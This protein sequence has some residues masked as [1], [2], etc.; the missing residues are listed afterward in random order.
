MKKHLL[1]F[2]MILL[3]ALMIPNVSANVGGDTATIH[4]TSSPS[5]ANVYDSGEYKGTTPCDIYV[6]TTGTPVNHNI[7]VSKSGY[8]DYHETIYPPSS[9]DYISV[10]AILTPIS[11]Q[12]YL[13]IQSSPSGANI[14]IDGSYRGTTSAVITLDSGTHNVRLEKPGYETW[15]GTATVY[16]DQ[17]QYLSPSL[18]PTDSYGHIHVSSTPSGADIYIDGY[19]KDTTPATISVNPGSHTVRVVLA[20]Y[21]TYSQNVILSSGETA[22][23][24]ADLS[25]STDAYLKISSNPGGASVYVDGNYMGNTGY[26]SGSSVNYMTIGP[27]STGGHSIMLKKDGY[28]TYTSSLTLAGNEVR[29]LSITLVPSSPGP[30]DTGALSMSSSPS[31]AELYIDNVFR[32]Y[33]PIYLSDI[34]PGQRT[35]LLKLNGYNDWTQY[36]NFVAGETADLDVPLTQG[37]PPS[38]TNTFFPLAGLLGVL[39]VALLLRRP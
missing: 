27:L 9:N 17:T 12:G 24:N 25:H 33:T 1:V 39:G 18:S 31:G 3:A 15:Y 21:D 36:V 11:Q 13:N 34:T 32:G 37:V 28:N 10:N 4:I 16:T 19:Y 2:L 29:S 22:Y 8:Y 5:G 20:G 23:L 38:P 35:L 30:Y 7:V 6:Y 26:S 14:Y